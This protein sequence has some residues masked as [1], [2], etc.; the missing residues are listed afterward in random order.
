MFQIQLGTS[1]YAFSM[2]LGCYLLGIALGSLAG[3]ALVLKKT[4]P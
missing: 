3:G 2:M 1:M 4:P